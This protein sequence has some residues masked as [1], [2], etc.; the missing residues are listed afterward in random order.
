MPRKSPNFKRNKSVAEL[1]SDTRKPILLPDSAWYKV[2]P[3]E[4]YQIEFNSPWQNVGG[5][6]NPDAQWHTDHSGENSEARV[7]GLVE[8]GDEGTVIFTLPDDTRP[9]SVQGFVCRVLGGG[10]ANILVYP[11]GDV[12]LESYNG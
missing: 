7:I 8:G 1:I 12:E 11:N 9:R 4:A 10:T 5:S 3:S 2:G 6:G